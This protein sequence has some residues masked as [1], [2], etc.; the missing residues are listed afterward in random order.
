MHVVG[1][2]AAEDADVD[3]FACDMAEDNTGDND[4]VELETVKGETK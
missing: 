1:A 2:L 3:V 4:L